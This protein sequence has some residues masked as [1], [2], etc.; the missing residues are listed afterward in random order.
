[1]GRYLIGV[2]TNRESYPLGDYIW[3]SLIFVNPQLEP[4]YFL[5]LQR[6]SHAGARLLAPLAQRAGNPSGPPCS[7]PGKHKKE[8]DVVDE[9][10]L[11]SLLVGLQ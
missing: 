5:H 3:E 2:L 4:C 7:L 9:F 11:L 8:V 6:Q 10:A 1:M